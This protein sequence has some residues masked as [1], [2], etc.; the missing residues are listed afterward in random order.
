MA[1]LAG[2]LVGAG[3]VAGF[4]IGDVRHA[5][6]LGLLPYYNPYCS[7]PVVIG[8]TTIDYSQP[9]VLAG[10][11]ADEFRRASRRRAVTR[12][13][14]TV[15]QPLL[16]AARDAFAHG[17]YDDA[18]AQCDKAIAQS[19]NDA[20]LHEFRG[21]ALFALHRYK[22]AAGTI[23]AVLSVGPGWDWTTMSG[24]YPDVDVYTEQLRALEQYV[25]ANP[26]AAEAR[27]LLAYH[28]MTCGHTDAA[29]EQFKAA[30]A[31][32]SQGSVVG[33]TRSAR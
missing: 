18:L 11:P 1:Q 5:V 9:I 12:R 29:A 33:P 6:V 7:A 14:P 21:L 27:F 15:P 22:E 23:Y 32:E 28:Y 16:D 20:V 4:G 17:D 2:R 8:D 26:N 10:P 31:T 30:V 25:D 19:P 13:R 24:F 3:F